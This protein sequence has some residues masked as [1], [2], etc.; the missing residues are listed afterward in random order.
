MSMIGYL[1][2]LTGISFAVTLVL[3]LLRGRRRTLREG[4]LCLLCAYGVAL[5]WQILAPTYGWHPLD[6][7]HRGMARVNLTPFA[8][9]RLFYRVGGTAAKINLAGNVLVFLPLGLLPPMIWE[10]CRRPLYGLLSGFLFS[11]TVECL[12]YFTGRS[13]DIDDLLLNTLGAALGWLLW[14]LYKSVKK[15]DTD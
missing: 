1:L 11:L 3:W 14:R 12:Q 5:G 7:L 8:T 6:F 15:T 10:K 9:L 4:L 2:Q 13:V